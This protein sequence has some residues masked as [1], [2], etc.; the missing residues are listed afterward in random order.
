MTD[1]NFPGT[2]VD[3]IKARM[4]VLV[5]GHQVVGRSLRPIDPHQTIGVFSGD[6]SPIPGSMEMSGPDRAGEPTLAR[7]TVNVQNMVKVADEEM[8]RRLSSVN[9]KIVRA[10]LYR[11]ATLKVSFAGLSETL[12]QRTE[13][14]ARHGVVRQRFLASE[15]P[16]A[17]WVY[18]TTT[19]VWFETQTS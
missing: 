16:R 6:W 5:P 13:R 19:E 1:A 7:Y 14:Y 12:M 11:D 10:V 4:G 17:G 3:L 18:L 2:F 9:A 15:L 8:G